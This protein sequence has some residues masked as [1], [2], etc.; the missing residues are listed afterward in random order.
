MTTPVA[1]TIM[2]SILF[3]I[4]DVKHKTNK[5]KNSSSTVQTSYHH[6]SCKHCRLHSLHS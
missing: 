4:I 2:I 1:E 3:I 5:T 6:S